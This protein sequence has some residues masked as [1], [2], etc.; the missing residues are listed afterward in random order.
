LC[1]GSGRQSG[2]R[3]RSDDGRFGHRAHPGDV[4]AEASCRV[5]TSRQTFV[6]RRQRGALNAPLHTRPKARWDTAGTRARGERGC[7]AAANRRRGRHAVLPRRFPSRFLGKHHL[8]ILL[9]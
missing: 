8:S 1:R 6:R 7:R 5:V 4:A 9:I 3:Q 2:E